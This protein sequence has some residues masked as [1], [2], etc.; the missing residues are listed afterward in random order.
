MK[1]L[2]PD[3]DADVLANDAVAGIHVVDD[4]GTQI[5]VENT[6][7][8]G[9]LPIPEVTVLRLRADFEAPGFVHTLVA[10][11]VS[12]HPPASA[13]IRRAIAGSRRSLSR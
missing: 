8:V 1:T 4:L 7:R 5:A 9:L 11:H 13:S 6:G 10:G 12:H 3:L 2:H